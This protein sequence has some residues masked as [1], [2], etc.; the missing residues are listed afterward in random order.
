MTP[1]SMAERGERGVGDQIAAYAVDAGAEVVGLLS[2][3]SR[4][5]LLPGEAGPHE[6]VDGFA[7]ADRALAPKPLDGSGDVVGE[8]QSGAHERNAFVS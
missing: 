3:R 6:F 1:C 8:R 7:H 4:R 5:G 2:K